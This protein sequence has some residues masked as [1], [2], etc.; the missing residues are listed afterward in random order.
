MGGTACRRPN[1]LVDESLSRSR[2]GHR[3]RKMM[4][5]KPERIRFVAC[6]SPASRDVLAPWRL[7][8]RQNRNMK[9]TDI[10]R[11][12]REQMRAMAGPLRHHSSLSPRPPRLCERWNDKGMPLAEPQRA[13][14]ENK[15]A[16]RMGEF[17]IRGVMLIPLRGISWR[18][19]GLA[20]DRTET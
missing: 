14:R 15:P 1:S 18:L 20:R 13:R 16:P 6:F 8:A 5:Y 17:P 12:R 9:T 4:R 2:R 3:E 10:I 11:R 19:C 7:G